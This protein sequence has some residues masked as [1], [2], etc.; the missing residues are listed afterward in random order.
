R[1]NQYFKDRIESFDDYYPCMQ[2]EDSECNLFH[3]YTGYNSLFLCIMIQHL[4]RII[5]LLIS[6]KKRW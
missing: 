1:V 6:Y 5:I 3:V 2:K 4:L